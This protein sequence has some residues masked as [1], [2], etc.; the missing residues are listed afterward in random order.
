MPMLEDSVMPM[1]E[2]SMYTLNAGL[3]IYTVE[4]TYEE[5]ER[6][7]SVKKNSKE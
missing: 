4:Q 6:G 2:N 7:G 5:K 3:K 1:L